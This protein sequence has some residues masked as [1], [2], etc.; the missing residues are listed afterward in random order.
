MTRQIALSNLSLLPWSLWK[1]PAWTWQIAQ[2]AG[3]DALKVNPLRGWDVATL[4][5]QTPSIP[6][7]AFEYLWR[8]DFSASCRNLWQHRDAMGFIA[9]ACFI[10]YTQA[11][12]RCA[13]YA[14]SDYY[15]ST[16]TVAIDFPL[17][18]HVGHLRHVQETECLSGKWPLPLDDD[19]L[20]CL[21]TWHVRTYPNPDAVTDRLMVEGRIATIDAQTRRYREW[22]DFHDGERTRLWEQLAR[23]AATPETVSASVEIAPQHLWRLCFDLELSRRAVLD[24]LCTRVRNALDIG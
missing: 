21:D 8:P 1:G 12:E 11:K 6:V 10:G 4:R 13:G 14:W 22:R 15:A 7:T 9:D 23:L 16:A 17:H 3:F 5:G 2:E 19:K 24:E 20:A 18:M